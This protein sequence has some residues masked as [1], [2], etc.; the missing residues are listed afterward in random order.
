MPDTAG[1]GEP[2]K[3]VLIFE[4][5]EIVLRALTL[6][7][8]DRGWEVY[9]AQQG[10]Q[11]KI[12]SE[13]HADA[14]V[15]VDTG[16]KQIDGIA[17]ARGLKTAN[18]NRVVIVMTGYPSLNQLLEGLYHET[19]DYLV[20]PFR[21]ELLDMV[22]DRA[23]REITLRRDNAN[24]K[25]QVKQLQAQLLENKRSATTGAASQQAEKPDEPIPGRQGLG[26]QGAA[27]IA[28]Y[29]RQIQSGFMPSTRKPAQQPAPDEM[30]QQPDSE[31]VDEEDD[32]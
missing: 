23:R 32:G 20:K 16:L 21:I 18:P 10:D 5:D 6:Q 12:L 28:S 15:L 9:T 29:E 2:A 11:A 31:P 26:E 7:L 13:E 3:S 8:K 22:I 17:L 19:F 27:A 24:L 30:T 25:N 1:Q 4:D 14:V